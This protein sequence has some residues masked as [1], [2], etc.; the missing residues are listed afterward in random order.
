MADK[1][2]LHYGDLYAN[3]KYVRLRYDKYVKLINDK[4]KAGARLLEIG[5]YTA[6]LADLLPKNVEYLGV[7]FDE[8]AIEIARSHGKKVYALNFNEEEFNFKEKFDI[9]VAAEILEH[10]VDPGKLITKLKELLADDGIIIISLPNENTLYHRIM[11]LFGL[12]VDMYPFAL[13]KH[14]HFPTIRQDIEF[15]SRYFKILRKEYYINPGGK[16]S[17]F[18]VAGVLFKLIPDFVWEKLAYAWPGC[19]AR[20]IIIVGTKL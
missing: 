15:V 20:G 16:G 17:R 14:L 4:S 8:K 7:D 12:G 5:C 1:A 11:S 9:V 19:F 6:T 10:L 13:Y 3:D 18:E 2:N